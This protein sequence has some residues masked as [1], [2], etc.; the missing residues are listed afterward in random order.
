MLRE[1]AAA[2]NLRVRLIVA[3]FLFSVVPLGA[4]TFFS[5]ANNL[6]ALRAAAQHVTELLTNELTRRMQAVTTQISER[7]EQLMDM[8]VST[9]TA[10]GTSGQSRSPASRT[11]AARSTAAKSTPKSGAST[12]A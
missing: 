12:S 7:V 10:T 5:Y 4:V 11:V 6:R 9:A 2:M 1:A 3:F 8:P